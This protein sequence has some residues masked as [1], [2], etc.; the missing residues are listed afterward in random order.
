MEEGYEECE[1][2]FIDTYVIKK[3]LRVNEIFL[4]KGLILEIKFTHLDN[5]KPLN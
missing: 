5:S 3:H 1:L 4:S 2:A